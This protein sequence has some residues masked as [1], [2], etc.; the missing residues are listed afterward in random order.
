MKN[1]K[2][3]GC[4][5]GVLRSFEIKLWRRLLKLGNRLRLRLKNARE[6]L[7]RRRANAK[8]R[9]NPHAFAQS[10]FKEKSNS[11]FEVSKEDSEAYFPNLYKDEDRSH[12]YS[13]LK[14]MLR[15]EK[16]KVPFDLKPP[17]EN[18]FNLALQRKRNAAAPGRDGIQYIVYSVY[19]VHGAFYLKK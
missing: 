7:L 2:E 15:P 11:R 5:T 16:P 1:L 9:S 10:L 18:E 12:S 19:R 3:K 14:E 13:P 8:F 4:F 17:N 6:S